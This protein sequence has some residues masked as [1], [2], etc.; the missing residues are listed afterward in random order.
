VAWRPL[1]FFSKKL[2]PAQRRYS[3]F[4]RELLA[5]YLAVRHFRFLLDG[6]Q[7]V[8]WP[9]H[10]PL[11]YALHRVSELWSAR[12][13]RQL[14]CLAKF[15]ASIQH[16]AGRDN[17]VADAL[18]RLPEHGLAS[19]PQSRAAMEGCSPGTSP[20]DASLI[21]PLLPPPSTPAESSRLIDYAQLAMAHRDCPDV[22]RMLKDSLLHI[23]EFQTE[24]GRP[25]L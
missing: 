8:I 4:D 23:R 12:Q 16:I 14:S 15:S 1:S 6:R 18:A 20:E 2:E 17:V 24:G 10:K 25:L 5:A 9:Y 3:A 13:Q 11:S 22:Q 7:F 21:A 19:R